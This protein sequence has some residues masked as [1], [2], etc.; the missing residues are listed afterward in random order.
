MRDGNCSNRYQR[1]GDEK[2]EEGNYSKKRHTTGMI[3]MIH[4]N[5]DFDLSNFE[6]RH[7]GV[8]MP[9]AEPRVWSFF[10]GCLPSFL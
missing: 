2:V 8:S 9:V 4:V 1:G 5:A 10:F 7:N 6:G 3:Y